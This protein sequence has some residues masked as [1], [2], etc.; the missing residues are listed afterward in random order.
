[1]AALT[2]VGAHLR[3]PLPVVP[4]TL[5]PTVVCLSGLWLGARGGA[6]SQIV[7][8][9]AGLI[10]FPIFAKGGGIH[11]VLEP[12]FGY[13]LGFVPAALT[14]GLLSPG[15][16]RRAPF[17]RLVVAAAIGIGVIYAFGITGLLLNLRYI[18]G[19]ELQWPQIAKLGLAP[20]PKDLMLCVIAAMLVERLRR[21]GADRH[22]P[23]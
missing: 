6:L 13:L 10:G 15:E 22:R 3:L 4:V 17:W 8:L 11:Y 14:A 21:L 12:T 20:L 23:H 2:A 1:M 9:V 7:Y 19:T 5:Q 18:T 16:H